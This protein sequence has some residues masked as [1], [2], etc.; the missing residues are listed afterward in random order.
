MADGTN[1]GKDPATI[2][3]EVRRT[4]D[5][6]GETVDRLEDKMNPRDMSRE[7][8][9]DEGTDVAKEALEV[10]RTNPIPVALIAI[11]II[12]LVA[13][14]NS[15]AIRRFTDKITGRR[16]DGDMDLR[17]RSQE[18]A[19]IGPPPPTGESFDRRAS[20]ARF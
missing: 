19:P 17:P 2:E 1:K 6:I 7:L 14:S 16:S 10:T 4:Q 13:S 11:G 8:L 18:P 20:E 9:G 15:P 12:W 5:E 3:N